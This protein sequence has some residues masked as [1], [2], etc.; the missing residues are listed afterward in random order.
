ML[1]TKPYYQVCRDLIRDAAEMFD[2]PRFIHLGMDE[3]AAR[4]QH[5][6][7]IVRTDE[8]WWHDL[9]FFCKAAE[10]LGMRPHDDVIAGL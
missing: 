5:G 4:Y 2:H 9:S 3:E 10:G 6:I 1:T 7:Q 8:L